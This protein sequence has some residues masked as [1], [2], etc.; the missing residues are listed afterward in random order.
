MEWLI[1]LESGFGTQQCDHSL[2]EVILSWLPMTNSTQ[3]TV[4]LLLVCLSVIPILSSPPH[5][6]ILQ[7][8]LSEE[9][10]A[11]EKQA[12]N[13]LDAGTWQL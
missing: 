10:S 12:G 8:C 4:C 5:L 3:C 11:R 13:L 1:T 7:P 2:A 6:N 9:L